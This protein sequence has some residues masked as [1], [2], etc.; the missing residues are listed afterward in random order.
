V[1][2]SP[3]K[4]EFPDVGALN[5]PLYPSAWALLKASKPSLKAS[6]NKNLEHTCGVP[7]LPQGYILSISVNREEIEAKG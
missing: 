3:L 1:P 6:L 7:V 5:P 2:N 4:P